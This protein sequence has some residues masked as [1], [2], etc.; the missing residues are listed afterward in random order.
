[1]NNEHKERLRK[2]ANL[3]REQIGDSE[4]SVKI[5]SDFFEGDFL[6]KINSLYPRVSTII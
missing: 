1:M 5:N 6:T 3:T 4:E 2:I